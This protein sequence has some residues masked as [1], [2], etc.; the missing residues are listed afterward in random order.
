MVQTAHPGPQGQLQISGPG[1]SRGPIKANTVWTGL[2][3]GPGD[4]EPIAK[5]GCEGT[6]PLETAFTTATSGDSTPLAE[7]PRLSPASG[8][9]RPAPPGPLL[10]PPPAAAAPETLAENA[11]LRLEEDPW[12]AGCAAALEGG[13]AHAPLLESGAHPRRASSRHENAPTRAPGWW[14]QRGYPG[15]GLS[16]PTGPTE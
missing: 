3:L 16:T 11:G 2:S 13:P 5:V 10:A 6:N 1:W 4:G 8:P 7:P 15:H 9:P 14:S 12:A